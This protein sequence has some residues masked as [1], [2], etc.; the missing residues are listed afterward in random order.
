MR[1]ALFDMDRTLVRHETAR[2]YLRYAREHGALSW[3]DEAK[4]LWW[5]AGYAAGL[6]DAREVAVRALCALEGTY[7]TVLAARCDDWFRRDVERHVCDAGRRAVE[8][9]RA[10]GEVVAIVT[11]AIPHVARPLARRL[12]IDHVVASE[13]EVAAD[14]RLT[15][16]LTGP[17]NY[18]ETKVARAAEL[19]S[20]LGFRVEEAAFYSDSS[21]DLPL[22][23]AVGQPVA[24]NPDA[25]LER[26]ARVR[27]WRIERW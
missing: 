1:A 7:E 20:R 14:G 11:A 9:H 4:A 6:V 16:R 2:L 18:A 10:R 19:A 26:V 22:L 3:A 8:E 21:S 17:L 25:K 5:M 27:G 15:G 24:V 23:Q 12:A 13:L